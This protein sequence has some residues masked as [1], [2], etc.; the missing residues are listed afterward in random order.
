MLGMWL[1]GMWQALT[2]LFLA[3]LI[4]LLGLSVPAPLT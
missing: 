2:F 4:V 1:G 3:I